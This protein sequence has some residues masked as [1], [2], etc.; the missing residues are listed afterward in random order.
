MK[1]WLTA[2][3]SLAVMVALSIA[4]LM[5]FPWGGLPPH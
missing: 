2:T 5:S 4:G 3:V 1:A